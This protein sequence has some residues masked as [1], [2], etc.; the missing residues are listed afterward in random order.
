[1][2]LDNPIPIV[3]SDFFCL[4]FFLDDNVGNDNV[5]SA[6]EIALESRDLR[7]GAQ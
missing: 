1:M 2:F 6:R 4:K 5:G 7:E 3:K